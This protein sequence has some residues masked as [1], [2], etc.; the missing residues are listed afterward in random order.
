MLSRILTAILLSLL[1]SACVLQSEV[2]VIAAT[3]GEPLLKDYG[4]RF[5]SYTLEN[6]AWKKEEDKIDFTVE[7]KHYLAIG[8]DATLDIAFR[9]LSGNWYVMQAAEKDKG[10]TYLLAEAKP[11]EIMVYPISCSAL[12]KAGKFG[13]AVEFKGD[14]CF[15]KQGADANALFNAV[16]A[17]PGPSEMKLVPET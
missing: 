1:L 7:G 3:E 12:D 2:P 15:I 16:L 11:G 10:A 5:A 14:D 6:G 13:D 17:M 4:L 8:K 9:E